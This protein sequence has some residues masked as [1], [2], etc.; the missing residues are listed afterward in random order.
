LETVVM[1]TPSS[2][3]IRFM[4][5]WCIAPPQPCRHGLTALKSLTAPCNHGV[6]AAALAPR[7]W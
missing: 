3:A 7:I 6:A 2:P 4:V 5:V 1:D